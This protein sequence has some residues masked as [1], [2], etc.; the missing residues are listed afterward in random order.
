MSPF[1]AYV[2][3]LDR[4][5]GKR[6]IGGSL[7]G[8]I[9][10]WT[11]AYANDTVVMAKNREALREMMEEISKRKKVRIMCRKNEGDSI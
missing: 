7:V 11:M 6:G 5:M 3:D 2:A 10:V 1:N 8:N 4:E 9:R